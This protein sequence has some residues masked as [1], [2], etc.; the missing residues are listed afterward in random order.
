[1]GYV[2]HA[3]KIRLK[4]RQT[5]GWG[6]WQQQNVNTSDRLVGFYFSLSSLTPSWSSWFFFASVWFALL[7]SSVFGS[8]WILCVPDCYFYSFN[9][10]GCFDASKIIR[11]KDHLCWLKIKHTVIFICI[12]LSLSYVL[13]LNSVSER[14]LMVLGNIHQLLV[15]Y[16]SLNYRCDDD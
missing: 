5:N 7:C 15:F 8:W 10:F 16:V 1:M 4:N 6:Q 3:H 2:S 9:S 11:S 13:S 14:I 12:Y